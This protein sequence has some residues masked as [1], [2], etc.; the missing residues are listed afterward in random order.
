[1]NTMHGREPMAFFGPLISSMDVCASMPNSI[2]SRM[3]L[4]KV[5]PCGA[6]GVV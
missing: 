6:Q 3:W 5:R 2:M 1:L 4:S